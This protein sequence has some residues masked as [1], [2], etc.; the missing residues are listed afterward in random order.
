MHTWYSDDSVVLRVYKL[1]ADAQK[2][3]E[4][5]LMTTVNMSSILRNSI[6]DELR[7]EFRARYIA[8]LR[9]MEN[10]HLQQLAFFY[11]GKPE[12]S[13]LL[14][15]EEAGKIS[16]ANVRSLKKGLKVVGRDDLAKYWEEFET[17]RNLALLL[18]ASMPKIWKD[19]PRQHRF[20]YVEAIL[21]PYPANYA[22]DENT[23]RSLRESKGSIEKVMISLKGQIET[24]LTE[25]CTKKLVLRLVD[26]RDLIS[27]TETKNEEFP[28]LLPEDVMR[29]SSEICSRMR[30]LD[31]WVRSLNG[32]N[33]LHFCGNNFCSKNESFHSVQK[34]SIHDSL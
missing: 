18:D 11:F 14:R 27:E 20:E 5:P 28:S 22:L 31:E 16:W 12:T 4:P 23:G 21:K 8:T 34:Y 10:D 29:C 13:N 17:L 15:I 1:S 30:S 24:F 6:T 7:Q 9:E 3:S 25:P 26:A 33:D 2:L 19:I 32:W